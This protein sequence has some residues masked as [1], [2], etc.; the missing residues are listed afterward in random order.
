MHEYQPDERRTHDEVRQ[1]LREDD[2]GRQGGRKRCQQQRVDHE[3]EPRAPNLRNGV[4]PWRQPPLS[5]RRPRVIP[6]DHSQY[7]TGRVT[8]A[9]C[10]CRKASIRPAETGT[11][12]SKIRSHGHHRERLTLGTSEA[13]RKPWALVPSLPT[14]YTT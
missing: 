4:H 3:A 11:A 14:E 9:A 5:H 10:H 8:L 6:D 1:T 12:Q 13:L 7:S 2:D